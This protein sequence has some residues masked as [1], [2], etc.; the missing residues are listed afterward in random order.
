MK[1]GTNSNMEGGGGKGG[2]IRGRSSSE[3][4]RQRSTRKDSILK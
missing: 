4:V 2:N 3:A 1:I